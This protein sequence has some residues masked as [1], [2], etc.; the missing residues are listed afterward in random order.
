MSY[1]GTPPQSGF[2]TTAKQRVT[3]STNAYVDLDHAISSIADVIVFVNF[4]KQDTT[5]LT[6]T[7]STRITLGATL[8]SS[9]IVEIHYLGKAVN[10]Q[11]PG[12]ATVTNDMLAGSIDLTSKVT[13]LLPQAN[14]ADQAINEAKLQISNSPV[15]GYMLTAQS[16]NTGGLTWAEAGSGAMTR[17]GG[18]SSTSQ[19]TNV[20]FDNVFTSTYT[21][22]LITVACQF[23]SNDS[24]LKLRMRASGSVD[25]GSGEYGWIVGGRGVSGTSESGIGNGQGNSSDDSY[26]VNQWGA[27]DNNTENIFYQIHVRNPLPSTTSNAEGN[28]VM[29]QNTC[30]LWTSDN[31]MTIQHGGGRKTGGTDNDGIRFYLTSGDFRTYDID[32]YGLQGS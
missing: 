21:Q 29:F 5:N 17:V 27:S 1:L 12:T 11:T 15:N 6:L 28:N 25:S 23:V 14:I 32:I 9:D 16:G 31:Y 3:S 13:G 8:V 30:T 18:A 22:Y 7:T 26:Q 2:I 4:V 24:H 20:D 10:T 19:V